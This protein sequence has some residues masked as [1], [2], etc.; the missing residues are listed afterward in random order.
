MRKCLTQRLD[1]RVRQE[2]RAQSLGRIARRSIHKTTARLAFR[3]V[4]FT[5]PT[6]HVDE[7]N[8][9]HRARLR[10]ARQLE[11]YR[12]AL[13]RARIRFQRR[14]R[15]TQYHRTLRLLSK[16]QRHVSRMIARRLPLFERTVVF[17]VDDDQTQ[18][19]HRR[20]QRTPRT[21]TYPNAATAYPRPRVKPFL[22]AQ[23]AV[24]YRHIL[25]KPSPEHR[26][27]L[28]RQRD[29][30][31]HKNAPSPALTHRFHH[32]KIDFRLATARH[33]VEQKTPKP[34]VFD[35]RANGMVLLIGAFH[36]LNYRQN[37]VKRRPVTRRRLRHQKPERL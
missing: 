35:D 13:K 27:K 7:G 37:I 19:P 11:K 4:R 25:A 24:Q 31:Q 32:P 17:L 20:K 34:F 12:F 21:D 2:M 30:R 10:T 5:F 3:L 16:H 6:A 15:R 23:P 22:I 36:R 28:R 8:F 29:F 18:F 33:P 14:R 9:R 26:A 1:K